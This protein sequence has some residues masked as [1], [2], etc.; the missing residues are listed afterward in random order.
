MR[1]WFIE[2][3]TIYTWKEVWIAVSAPLAVMAVWFLF[4]ALLT[5]P[6]VLIRAISIWSLILTL[7]LASATVDAIRKRQ[8]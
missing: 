2:L 3:L 8:R 6:M 1:H 7:T 4:C 5:I